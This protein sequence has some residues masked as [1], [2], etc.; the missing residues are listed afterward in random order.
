MEEK[1]LFVFAISL[2]GLFLLILNA[3]LFCLKIKDKESSY[4]LLTAFLIL[5]AFSEIICNVTGITNPGTNLI[6]SHAHYHLHFIFFSLIYY[7]LL[8]VKFK[9]PMIVTAII[10]YLSL[11]YFYAANPQMVYNISPQETLAISIILILY[12]LVY[13]FET[14]GKQKRYYYLSLG[15]IL[16]LTC[17]SIVFFA[18]TLNEELILFER[19]Y[20]DVWVFNSLFFIIYQLLIFKEWKRLTA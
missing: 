9:K 18:G 12:A 5:D 20:V 15:L 4:K 10:L 11:A 17:S 2:V 14:L 7:N 13:L 16:Y 8:S 19:P 6:L 1:L 3:L